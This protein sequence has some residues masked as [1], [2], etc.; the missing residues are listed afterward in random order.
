[1][2][3]NPAALIGRTF[4]GFG[5]EFTLK[6][7]AVEPRIPGYVRCDASDG[8]TMGIEAAALRDQSLYVEVK[9]R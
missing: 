8:R 1:M 2:I 6:V 7:V 4:R 3:R 9:A 5:D